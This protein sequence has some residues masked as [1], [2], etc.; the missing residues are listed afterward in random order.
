VVQQNDSKSL[1]NKVLTILCI[2]DEEP[3]L[4]VRRAML[5]AAG[6]RVVTGLSGSQGIEIFRSEPVDCVIL[7]YWMAGKNGLAVARELKRINRSVPII[8]LSAYTYL[9]DE[10]IGLVDL[11]VQKGGDSQQLL[12]NVEKLLRERPRSVAA[13]SEAK[14]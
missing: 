10:T 1:K 8:M 14:S 13:N 4:L 11:W 9:P 7:D 2:D 3:G 6:Y 12:D 5:E